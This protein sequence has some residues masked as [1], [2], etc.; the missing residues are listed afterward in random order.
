LIFGNGE[1]LLVLTHHLRLWL[2][3]EVAMPLSHRQQPFSLVKA[4]MQSQNQLIP[5]REQLKE[6]RCL[7][8]TCLAAG[9]LP[10]NGNT[11]TSII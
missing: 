5:V 4:T 8:P 11:L 6:W 7:V 9:A 2:E 10:H 3:S 1:Y